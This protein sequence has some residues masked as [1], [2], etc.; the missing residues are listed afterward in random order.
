[1]LGDV[2][3]KAREEIA[4]VPLEEQTRKVI[5]DAVKAEREADEDE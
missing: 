5:D 2:V 3:N 4:K 1:M